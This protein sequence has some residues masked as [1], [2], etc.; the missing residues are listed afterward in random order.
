[1]ADGITIARYSAAISSG[2]CEI[3]RRDRGGIVGRWTKPAVASPV[4]DVLSEAISL[5]RTRLG[6]FYPAS[7]VLLYRVAIETQTA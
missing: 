4:C 1:M 6:E 3:T 5:S 2:L 7:R